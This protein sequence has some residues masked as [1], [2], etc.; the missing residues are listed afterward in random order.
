VESNPGDIMIYLIL[1]GVALFIVVIAMFDLKD[2]VIRAARSHRNRR[3]QR[4]YAW[5]ALQAKRRTR[6]AIASARPNPDPQS[7]PEGPATSTSTPSER[8]VATE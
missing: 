7:T 2:A 1:G 4:E 5:L 6:Q 3:A 8:S